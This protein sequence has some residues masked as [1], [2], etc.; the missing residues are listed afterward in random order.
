MKFTKGTNYA[1]HL[2]AYFVKHQGKENLSLAPLAA[3]L[4]LSPTYLSKILTQLVKAELV[5]STPGVNGGYS[6]R[7][8]RDQISFY[9][10]IEAIEGSGSLFTCEIEADTTCL[11]EGVMQNA[12]AKMINYLKETYLV[13]VALKGQLE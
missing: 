13:E 1:L 8:A 5:Y 3:H 10:V 4:N 12:E 9:D 11:I 2:M 6:L 7:K